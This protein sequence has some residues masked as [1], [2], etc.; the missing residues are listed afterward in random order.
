MPRSNENIFLCMLAM[1]D[2]S[3]PLKSR[4]LERCSTHNRRQPIRSKRWR[5]EKN[6]LHKVS[7]GIRIINEMNRLTETSSADEQSNQPSWKKICRHCL[8][9]KECESDGKVRKKE[10]LLIANLAPKMRWQIVLMMMMMPTSSLPSPTPTYVCPHMQAQHPD[11][12][13]MLA[14]TFSSEWARVAKKYP[15]AAAAVHHH[16]HDGFNSALWLDR[17]SHH[18]RRDC[19]LRRF[20]V[21]EPADSP[22]YISHIVCT[23]SRSSSILLWYFCE[24]ANV[25]SFTATTTASV[26]WKR[27][28]N[29]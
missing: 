13:R 16:Y 19:W 9:L 1:C 29:K 7:G 11:G 21:L 23:S 15:R 28:N 3:P 10:H 5:V 14:V 27:K 18:K 2:T 4:A 25:I 24:P 8:W 22:S 26:G 6:N 12:G 20:H 17:C